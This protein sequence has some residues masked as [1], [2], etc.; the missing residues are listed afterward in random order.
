M[1][2]KMPGQETAWN[3]AGNPLKSDLPNNIGELAMV[4]V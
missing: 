4:I 3:E 2:E 1:P